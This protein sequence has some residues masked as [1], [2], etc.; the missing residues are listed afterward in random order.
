MKFDTVF[1]LDGKDQRYF[2]GILANL[3]E[4]GIRKDEIYVQNMVTDYQQLESSK[5]KSWIKIAQYYI[6]QRVS[7][8]DQI[9]PS[10]KIP[11][12]LTSELLYKALLNKGEKRIQAKEFYNLKTEIPIP[13]SAN[14]LHRPLIPF[15]RH[16][17]YSLS[18]KNEYALKISSLIPV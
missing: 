7:E 4:I 14:Q 3:N 10:R 2:A 12:L 6:S 17:A 18:V 1:N 5:N 16:Y 8:F 11:V 13:T 9:D 15:Y